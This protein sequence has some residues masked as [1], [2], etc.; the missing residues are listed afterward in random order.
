MNRYEAHFKKVVCQAFGQENNDL[1]W[2]VYRVRSLDTR[3]VMLEEIYCQKEMFP[4]LNNKALEGSI[5]TLFSED[6]NIAICSEQSS[7][8]ITALPDDKAELL[9]LNAGAPCIKIIRKRF[10]W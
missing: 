1:Y 10:K 9:S 3:P 2:K 7:I 8:N 4:K 5:T 6:Y